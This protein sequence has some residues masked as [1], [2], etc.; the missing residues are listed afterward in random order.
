[1]D[2]VLSL[3]CVGVLCSSSMIVF[4]LFRPAPVMIAVRFNALFV[5]INAC[6]IT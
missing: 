4:N 2:D 5:A 1:M 3:R 6:Y